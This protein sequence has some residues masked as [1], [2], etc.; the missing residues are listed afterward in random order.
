L[1]VDY[2]TGFQMPKWALITFGILSVIAGVLALSWPGLTILVLVALLGIQLLVYGV[3][4]V[5]AAFESGQSRVLA[6]IFAVLAFIAGTSLFLRPM[7]NL[8]AIVVVLSVFWVVGGLVQ[9]IG[10]IVDR[11]EHWVL[12]LLSGLLSVAAG[13]VAL[14]WPEITLLVIAITAGIWMIAIGLM[15]IFSA[16]SGPRP[17]MTAAPAV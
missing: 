8:G 17:S 16:F 10:S 14:V 5:F 15:R 6:V 13:V 9:T 11:D 1:T 4:V 7:R 3:M 12:E 2:A